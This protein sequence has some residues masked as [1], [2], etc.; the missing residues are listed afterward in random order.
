M[1]LITNG[2]SVYNIEL[3]ESLN[4]QNFN[5]N[6]VLVHSETDQKKLDKLKIERILNPIELTD[7]LD[8]NNEELEFI[9]DDLSSIELSKELWL[10]GCKNQ[11]PVLFTFTDP[12]IKSW[13]ESQKATPFFWVLF[14]DVKEPDV[15]INLIINRDT[16]GFLN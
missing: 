6:Y 15:I 16:K 4:S 12:S 5:N 1:L 11:V 3:I 14:E 2:S 13:I 7:W 8:E 9:I 10:F